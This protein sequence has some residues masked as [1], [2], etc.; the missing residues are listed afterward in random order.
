M[1]AKERAA[2]QGYDV[3]A[4]HGTFKTFDIFTDGDIGFHFAKDMTCA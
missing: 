2:S 3:F 4:Y 1:L